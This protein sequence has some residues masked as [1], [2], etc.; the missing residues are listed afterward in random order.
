MKQELEEALVRDFP[1]L[2]RD[3]G[4]DMAKTC[5]AWGFDCGDGWESLIRDLSEK[6]TKVDPDCVAAQVKE[7]FGGLRFYTN[8]NTEESYKAICEAETLS[9]KTCEI[10]GKP[11]SI[12]V[13]GWLRCLCEECHTH[14]KCEHKNVYIEDSPDPIL[15]LPREL[16]I[17]K[18]CGKIVRN[19]FSEGNDCD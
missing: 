3:Y 8:G 18:D 16:E 5:M 6:I 19:L 15:R 17:C 1:N 2:Y 10:C 11:G 12:R 7:K 9:E 13:G 14:S 4:G